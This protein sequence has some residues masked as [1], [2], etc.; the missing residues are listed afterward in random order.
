MK[1]P[2]RS[3]L[4]L[5][6]ASAAT[7]NA[8]ISLSSAVGLSVKADPKV[9]SAAAEVTRARA[10]LSESKDAFVPVVSANGGVGDSAGVPL[11]LPI[12][13]SI[14]A[15]S[16]AFNWSQRDYIRAAHL[17]W[18]ASQL[19]LLQAENDDAQDVVSSY[20]E[21]DYAMQ[22]R[23]A[24]REAMEHASQL[25][26]V[27]QNRY[28]SGVGARVEIPRAE[29]QVNQIQLQLNHIESDIAELSDHLAHLTGLPASSLRIDHASLPD[30]PPTESLTNTADAP[31]PSG[32]QAAFVT[33]KSKMEIALGDKRYLYR[34]QVEFSANYSRITTD[35]SNYALY[36]PGFDPV[37]AAKRAVPFTPSYNALSLGVQIQLPLLDQ[38]HRAK[39]RQ[40]MA[41]AQKA[42]FDA[43]DARNRYLEG[44][45]KMQRAATD[46]ELNTRIAQNNVDIQQDELEA[47]LVQVNAASVPAQG[48]QALTPA[49]EQKA[50]I[51]VAQKKLD[52][53][54]AQ[55]QLAKDKIEIMHGNGTLLSWLGNKPA[56]H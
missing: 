48:Q 36:Y 3:L 15:Q 19:A 9:K 44:R 46:L 26:R 52:L 25:L 8:Q 28:D 34:P 49:D 24:A 22:R 2:A 21:L 1:L 23:L 5:L 12:I 56:S 16:L 11:G 14:Q 43:E 6:V 31:L 53:L 30:F 13:F 40:S 54:D 18:D 33:A 55:L 51:G 47:T 17:G 35:F 38:A 29:L 20:I 42:Q 7:A 41:E 37:A 4:L 10:A 45:L 32:V 39:A 50:R 27:S